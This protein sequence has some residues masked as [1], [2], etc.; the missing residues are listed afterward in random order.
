VNFQFLFGRQKVFI[1]ALFGSS[2]SLRAYRSSN[3][4]IAIVEFCEFHS[5]GA[6]DA[7]WHE[8]AHTG[9]RTSEYTQENFAPPLLHR[10][11]FSGEGATLYT[12]RRTCGLPIASV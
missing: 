8:P 9:I 4:L 1:P 7:Q 10:T 6:C 12:C 11:L 5:D 3:S 2:I